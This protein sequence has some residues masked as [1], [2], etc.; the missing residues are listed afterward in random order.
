MAKR[1]VF[2]SYGHSDAELIV[3]LVELLRVNGRRVFVD[4]AIEPGTKWKKAIL[5]SL[6]GADQFVL[7][8]C[9][10]SAGS[11][12][13]ARE[14]RIALRE[15]KRV[16]P[17]LLCGIEPP[18]PIADYEWI[19]L[20]GV[21][22]HGCIGHDQIAVDSLRLFQTGVI[23]AAADED[24]FQFGGVSNERVA[25]AGEADCWR[26][27]VTARSRSL[28]DYPRLLLTIGVSLVI[29]AIGVSV[30]ASYRP[31]QAEAR[32]AHDSDGSRNSRYGGWRLDASETRTRSSPV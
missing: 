16:V 31:F 5:E 6:R 23:D 11:E 12:W 19:D 20:S 27:R 14:V 10:H 21:V 30:L 2:V 25:I 13:V 26:A 28:L 3:P 18:K 9:C 15:A 1:G 8:W 4:T 22:K 32:V 7:I 17:V 24:V 29:A